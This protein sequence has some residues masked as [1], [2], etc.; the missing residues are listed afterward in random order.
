[1]FMNNNH[2]LKKSN[3]TIALDASLI[4]SIH[5]GKDS[6]MFVVDVNDYLGIQT[7]NL[8]WEEYG[9]FPETHCI[10]TGSW[11]RYFFRTPSGM[12]VRN[13]SHRSENGE[14]LDGIII[15]GEGYCLVIYPPLSRRVWTDYWY[16][17]EVGTSVADAPAW[18]LKKV[19]RKWEGQP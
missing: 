5:L 16:V 15:R 13:Q 14:R 12:E 7:R 8:W 17:S 19:A 4:T 11:R 3:L 1:M 6:G 10:G 2:K 9:R 18:L